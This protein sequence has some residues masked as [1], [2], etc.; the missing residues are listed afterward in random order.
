MNRLWKKEISPFSKHFTIKY[1]N[2]LGNFKF[3]LFVACLL[4]TIASIVVAYVTW[5]KEIEAGIIASCVFFGVVVILCIILISRFVSK[6]LDIIGIRE[7]L[8]A[9][10]SVSLIL[11]LAVF[12]VGVSLVQTNPTLVLFL[13]PIFG[14]IVFYILILIS[15]LYAFW[16]EKN[17]SHF[18]LSA[19][20]SFKQL[21]TNINDTFTIG[22]GGGSKDEPSTTTNG[23]K[24]S[25]NT[26]SSGKRTETF[27]INNNSNNSNN[28][29]YGIPSS[30]VRLP[31]Q[32]ADSKTA[33]VGTVGH[34][35]RLSKI[36]TVSVGAKLSP[37]STA[38]SSS[39]SNSKNGGHK[40]SA[41][42]LEVESKENDG[43]SHTR[44][45]SAQSNVFSLKKNSQSGNTNTNSGDLNASLTGSRSNGKSS[46]FITHPDREYRTMNALLTSHSG[47]T[48]FAQHLVKEYSLEN[49]LFVVECTQFKLKH[50]ELLYV[51]CIFCYLSAQKKR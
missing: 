38:V 28:M 25:K 14:Q 23:T 41:S 47:F 9:S 13:G 30:P 16:R 40:K 4:T 15:T 34:W 32:T 18:I 42:T 46:M 20:R 37:P 22:G 12:I 49:L 3:V 43:K 24:S 50:K 2:T 5:T 29:K 35:K 44:S 36:S 21:I 10:L 7:E 19:K 17:D 48:L 6:Y 45:F 27:S 8:L 11:V 33:V 26:M 51:F 31:F 1:R 39:K